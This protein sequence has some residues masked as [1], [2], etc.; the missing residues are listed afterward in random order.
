[1]FLRCTRRKK[2][3]KLHEYCS[4]VENRRLSDGRSAQRQVLY[5]GEI[6]ASQR[7]VW[8]KTVEVLDQGKQ[9]QV[10]LFPSGSMPCD[11]VDAVGVCLSESVV[12]KLV[13]AW[14]ECQAAFRSG[15][16]C[17]VGFSG[18]RWTSVMRV[19]FRVAPD[20]R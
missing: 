11:D 14:N 8:R 20:H 4:I 5:L 1:M 7:E 12:V 16:F 10:A 15:I 6:N 17:S 9:R 13:V 19:Q 18:L 3:G 2:D